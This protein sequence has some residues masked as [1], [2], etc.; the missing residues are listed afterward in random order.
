MMTCIR[1]GK[2]VLHDRV[3]E[4]LSLYIEDGKIAA[5]TEEELPSDEVIDAK[6]QYVAPGFIDM[7][8]HGGGGE[9]FMDGGIEPILKAA[10]LHL[11]HGTT[12]LN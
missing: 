5:L 4:G 7:H 2:V 8:L 6:G 1:N 10:E 3:A 11:S 9:D 12:H